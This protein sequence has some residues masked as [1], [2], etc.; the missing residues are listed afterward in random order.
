MDPR[1][2][3]VEANKD[4]LHSSSH[5]MHPVQAYIEYLFPIT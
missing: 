3:G 5:F 4:L 2:V 1:V